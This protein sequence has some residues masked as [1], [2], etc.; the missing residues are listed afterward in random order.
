MIYKEEPFA[1][2]LRH[3]LTTA[4]DYATTIKKKL[5]KKD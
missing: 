5:N 3:L 1:N 2:Y 4:N